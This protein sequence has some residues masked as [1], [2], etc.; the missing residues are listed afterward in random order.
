MR[1]ERV[2]WAM[3]DLERMGEGTI[4]A[5]AGWQVQDCHCAVVVSAA[6]VVTVAG[7]WA[8]SQQR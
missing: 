3:Q 6:G 4:M 5:P 1:R 2:S 7:E 8:T